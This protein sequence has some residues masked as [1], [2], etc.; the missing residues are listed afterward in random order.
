MRRGPLFLASGGLAAA[1]AGSLYFGISLPN[2]NIASYIAGHYHE[3]S[4]DA[5]ATRYACTGSPGQVA[6][7]LANDQGPEARASSGATQYLRYSNNIVVVGPESNQPCS[8]RVE[9]LSSGYSHGAYRS[10][11][12]GFSPGSPSRST[13]GYSGGPRSGK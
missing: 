1:A 4:R 10:L 9:P 12:P 3:Y 2:K 5:N 7:T 11:G 13:G 8:V 6:N